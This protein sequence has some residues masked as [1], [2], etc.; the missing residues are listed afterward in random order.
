MVAD[1]RSRDTYPEDAVIAVDRLGNRGVIV[2]HY[3]GE[4]S[5][6]V[7]LQKIFQ[8]QHIVEVLTK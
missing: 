4:H 3:T 8:L 7:V 6:R 5:E 2:P 1:S